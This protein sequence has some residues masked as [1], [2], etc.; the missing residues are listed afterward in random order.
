MALFEG[1]ERRIAGIQKVLDQYGFKTIEETRELCQS[2]GFD[3]YEIVRGVQPICFENA[4]WAYTLGC[5]IALKCDVKTAS[6]AAERIGEGLQ[7][8]CVPGR[9]RGRR[10]SGVLRS[11]L[12]RR[13]AQSRDRTREPGRTSAPR[14]HEVLLLLGRP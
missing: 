12:S 13:P 9:K 11:G 4:C 3:P 14:G 10:F 7:A 8:F 6:E 1:Y 5:A 2:K